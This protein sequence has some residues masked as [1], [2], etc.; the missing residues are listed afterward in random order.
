M[1]IKLPKLDKLTSSN[2]N[3]ESNHISKNIHVKNGFAFVV[4]EIVAAVDIRKYIESTVGIGEDDIDK[5]KQ[6]MKFIEGQSFTPE[7]WKYLTNKVDVVVDEEENQLILNGVGLQVGL[8]NSNSNPNVE[9]FLDKARERFHKANVSKSNIS[10][11]GSC[12]VAI[13]KAFSTELAKDCIK[14]DSPIE[15][16]HI[17][18]QLKLKSFIFGYFHSDEEFS[19]QRLRNQYSLEFA[20]K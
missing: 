9:M 4:N 14:F 5:I 18:F 12:I 6:F 7:Y 2:K 1:I 13:N 11:H 20:K 3:L 8:S 19:N 16:N 15:D 17:R 10:M